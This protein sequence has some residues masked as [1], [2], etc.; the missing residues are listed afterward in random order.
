MLLLTTHVNLNVYGAIFH[1]FLSQE[2]KRFP[3]VMFVGLRYVLAQSD[4]TLVPLG[5]GWS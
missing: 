4:V 5:Y 2:G 3:Y 1:Q